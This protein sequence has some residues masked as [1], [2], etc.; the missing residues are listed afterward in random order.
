MKA[1]LFAL[2]FSSVAF[3]QGSE[4]GFGDLPANPS[5]RDL[6]AV[7]RSLLARVT[8][9]ERRVNELE[10]AGANRLTTEPTRTTDPEAVRLLA[11]ATEERTKLT[12]HL[13]GFTRAD[14][15]DARLQY[16]LVKR[17]ANWDTVTAD[18]KRFTDALKAVVA[19]AAGLPDESKS[20]LE[21][22]IRWARGRTIYKVRG[23]NVTNHVLLPLDFGTDVVPA[24]EKK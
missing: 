19:K 12:R 15:T 23:L 5:E 17:D 24:D 14:P 22:Q 2:V 9:L 18:A 7:V 20:T 4:P 21:S 8:E 13:D 3:A 6:T 10:A 1:I 11:V 16:S